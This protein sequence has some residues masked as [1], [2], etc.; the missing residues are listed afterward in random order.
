MVELDLLRAPRIVDQGAG[1]GR[2]GRVSAQAESVERVRAQLPL[3]QGNGVVGGEDPLLERSL[4]SRLLDLRVDL[5]PSESSDRE[6]STSLGRALISSSATEAARSGPVNSVAR[7][8]PVER[9]SRASAA[10]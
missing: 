10:W 8:S 5:G 4:R 9:S 7:K 6:T 1:G 3:Q 2:R